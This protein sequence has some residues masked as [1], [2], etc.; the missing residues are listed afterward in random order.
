MNLCYQIRIKY[1]YHPMKVDKLISD[2]SLACRSG[3]SVAAL[4][5]GLDRQGEHRDCEVGLGA[6]KSEYTC[7]AEEG[8]RPFSL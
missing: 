1:E 7:V 5:H 4:Q 2:A 3:A 8:R 6:W